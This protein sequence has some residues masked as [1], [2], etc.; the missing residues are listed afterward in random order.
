M[1]KPLPL[2]ISQTNL[3]AFFAALT[4][5]VRVLSKQFH[6]ERK[7]A[8]LNNIFQC[9]KQTVPKNFR[10]QVL[11]SLLYHSKENQN[12]SLSGGIV[13]LKV[14]SSSSQLK[15]VQISSGMLMVCCIYVKKHHTQLIVQ[16]LAF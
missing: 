4:V 3:T 15:F 2:V 8:F 7:Y 1:E 13:L 6:K 5:F 14:I 16:T 10:L 11:T 12:Q 9:S